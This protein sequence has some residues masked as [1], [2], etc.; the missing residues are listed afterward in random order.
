MRYSYPDDWATYSPLRRAEYEREMGAF[1][2][3]VRLLQR[4][5]HTVLWSRYKRAY[6]WRGAWRWGE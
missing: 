5:R 4:L 2:R 3:R 1:G 6:W